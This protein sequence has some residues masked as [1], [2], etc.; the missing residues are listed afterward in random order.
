MKKIVP[1][2]KDNNK[3]NSNTLESGEFSSSSWFVR[4]HFPLSADRL[5]ATVP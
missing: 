4:T 3:E 1:E 5:I 2:P